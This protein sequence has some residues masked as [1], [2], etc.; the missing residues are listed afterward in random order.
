M[1]IPESAISLRDNGVAS[2]D[3][4]SF[5]LLRNGVEY[6]S[7]MCVIAAELQHRDL[8][9]KG[10]ARVPIAYSFAGAIVMVTDQMER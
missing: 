6:R 5:F 2:E 7:P 3:S 8:F 10:G 1:F 4:S 9:V